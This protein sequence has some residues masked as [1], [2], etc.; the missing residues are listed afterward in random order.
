MSFQHSVPGIY[1]FA[2]IYC[3]YATEVSNT[4]FKTSL[5]IE[6]NFVAGRTVFT[7]SFIIFFLA[8]TFSPNIFSI[9]HK[10][11]QYNLPGRVNLTF[12]VGS[13]RNTVLEE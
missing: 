1:N 11:L 10:L 12:N 3:Y 4:S 8:L 7:F 13:V 6:S 2:T 9:I 5:S